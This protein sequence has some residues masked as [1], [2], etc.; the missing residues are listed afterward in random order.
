MTVADDLAIVTIVVISIMA[1]GCA[2][3]V[4]LVSIFLYKRHRRRSK[5]Q[6]D[7]MQLSSEVYAFPTLRPS[8]ADPCEPPS[9]EEATGAITSRN[10]SGNSSS[11]SICMQ[12]VI[13][14]ENPS[15]QHDED[16]KK[17]DSKAVTSHVDT[18]Q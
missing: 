10:D 13:S 18:S 8:C 1:G 15:Y 4:I 9:Y 16:E 11:S 7:T 3:I 2:I 17:D 5:P 14:V 12:D 6:Q